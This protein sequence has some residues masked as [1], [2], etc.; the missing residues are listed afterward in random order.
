MQISR[1]LIS[2]FPELAG[3]YRVGRAQNIV[4]DGLVTK[5]GKHTFEVRSTSRDKRYMISMLK[6]ECQCEDW[7][8]GHVCKHILACIITMV[9]AGEGLPA[10]LP[11]PPASQPNPPTQ[12][13]TTWNPLAWAR[14]QLAG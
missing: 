7:H 3:D 13:R 1:Q 6:P 2:Q 12:P 8:K 10:A 14:A 5:L 4:K 9:L 11:K